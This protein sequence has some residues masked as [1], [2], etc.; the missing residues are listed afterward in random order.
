MSLQQFTTRTALALV[1]VAGPAHASAAVISAGT[2][3]PVALNTIVVPIEISGAVNVVFSQFDLAYDPTDLQINTGC[4]PFSG[5]IYCG[6]LT[7]PITEGPFFGS[8][9]PF[10]VFNPGFITEQPPGLQAGLLLAVNDTFGGAP[11]GPSGS[12][13]LAY[14]EF[15]VIGAGNSPIRVENSTVTSAVPEPATFA[16]FLVSTACLNAR[17]LTRHLRRRP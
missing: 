5:D 13:V 7:G 4:D 6:F 1:L 2:A 14:V 12:G 16:L 9:S 11:P 15:L 10:N 8:L 17:L 3:I